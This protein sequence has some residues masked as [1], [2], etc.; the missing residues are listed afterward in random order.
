MI[1]V[2]SHNFH[3]SDQS[4]EICEKRNAWWCILGVEAIMYLL[5]NIPISSKS[6]PKHCHMPHHL[7]RF[8]PAPYSVAENIGIT[9]RISNFTSIYQAI[10]NFSYLS[11]LIWANEV[12]VFIIEG[13]KEFYK[14]SKSV[15]YRLKLLAELDEKYE[16]VVLKN[17]KLFDLLD[18]ESKLKAKP[19]S[20]ANASALFIVV[21]FNAF[22]MFYYESISIAYIDVKH[23]KLAEKYRLKLNV[24]AESL[25]N[26]II[27]T[28]KLRNY[29]DPEID[30][31]QYYISSQIIPDIFVSL[32]KLFTPIRA[33]QDSDN[34]QFILELVS[35]FALYL[36]MS[37]LYPEWCTAQI[38]TNGRFVY[39]KEEIS[40]N[41]QVRIL[42]IFEKSLTKDFFCK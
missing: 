40:K 42:K 12:I 32:M 7:L 39:T 24:V 9:A 11:I 16:E 22:T 5:Y 28:M 15:D 38:K 20:Y 1:D 37:Q 19:S 23:F 34:A 27:K 4:L 18:Y 29:P 14:S 35:E 21:T 2:Y 10:P 6:N 8:S 33:A 13:L 41:S 26:F 25:F 3:K 17:S 30:L 36:P 31:T